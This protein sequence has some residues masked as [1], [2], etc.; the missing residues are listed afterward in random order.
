MAFCHLN[1]WK[2]YFKQLLKASARMQSIRKSLH[3]DEEGNVQP[4][5]M[6]EKENLETIRQEEAEPE[7]A[8]AEAS[9]GP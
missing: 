7:H 4:S 5:V 8:A 9:V 6:S 1:A 3:R 2:P